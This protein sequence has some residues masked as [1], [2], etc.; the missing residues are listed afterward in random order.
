MSYA[1]NRA[2][3]GV[4]LW[5][6]SQ[7]HK[8]GR[9]DPLLQAVKQALSTPG[10]LAIQPTGQNM[11]LSF[12][13]APLGSYRVQWTTNLTTNTWTSLMVTNLSSAAT[14]GVLQVTDPGFANRPRRVYRVRTPP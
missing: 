2:L 8:S 11:G 14:G 4:I 6:V 5:E 7:D 13:S 3:G 9:P 10:P 12:S 1:R